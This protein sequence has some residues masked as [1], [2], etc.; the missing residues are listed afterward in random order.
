MAFAL[1]CLCPSSPMHRASAPSLSGISLDY[2]RNT[3]LD[4]ETEQLTEKVFHPRSG[5]R[6]FDW[7]PE[8]AHIQY[9]LAEAV[10]GPRWVETK[11]RVGC[12]GGI[13]S[14]QPSIGSLLKAY[15]GLGEVRLC[16]SESSRIKR[17]GIP[18]EKICPADVAGV[19][20]W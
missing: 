13:H 6:K 5:D 9:G 18:E 17:D 16:L 14:C 8:D 20:S 7:V 10:K 12:V 2:P 15:C 3:V 19:S 4:L 11:G 1:P